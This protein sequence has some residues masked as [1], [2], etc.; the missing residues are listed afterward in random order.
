MFQ[1]MLVV[2]GIYIALIIG[3]YNLYRDEYLNNIEYNT[4]IHGKNQRN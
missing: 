1:I 4:L 3:L 2:I